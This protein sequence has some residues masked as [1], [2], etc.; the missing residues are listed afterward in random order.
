M[1]QPAPQNLLDLI[2]RPH[3]FFEALRALPP[4]PWRYAWLPALSGLVGGV[5]QGLLSRPVLESFSL[6]F[7][8]LPFALVWGAT[9]VASM[10][11]SL[12]LWLLLWGLGQLGAGKEG[13]SGEVYAASFLAPLL[14]AVVLLVL[15]L[16]SPP[17]VKVAAPDFAGLDLQARLTAFQTYALALSV[18]LAQWPLVRFSSVMGNAI[19]LVQFW[20]AY[21]GFRVMTAEPDPAASPTVSR[22]RAWKGVL[23]P[24]G[25]LLLLG[26]AGVL[27]A[28]SGMALSG[29]L[30]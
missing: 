6:A 1:I 16:A 12:L 19:Y 28:G 27:V 21:I 29:G 11:G 5:S 30:G 13:R 26:L 7:P 8:G 20:L 18:Q 25:L 17:Q 14:W 24:G 22:G 10:I 3:A 4:A 2:R 23:Y 15:A 9:V